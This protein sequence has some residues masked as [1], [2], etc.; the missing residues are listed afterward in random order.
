MIILHYCLIWI[1]KFHFNEGVLLQSL[2]V[3]VE[4]INLNDFRLNLNRKLIILRTWN[5]LSVV[6]FDWDLKSSWI[7]SSFNKFL[8]IRYDR[9][10]LQIFDFIKSLFWW[11]QDFI[12]QNFTWINSLIL[13]TSQVQWNFIHN[14]Y[15]LIRYLIQ[16]IHTWNCN[17]NLTIIL[18]RSFVW[19]QLH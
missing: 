7:E 15:H 4:F 2:I 11:I 12:W 19:N 5:C 17:L 8:I 14:T 18:Q 10:K 3:K 16:W 13:W 6:T 1:W 9:L